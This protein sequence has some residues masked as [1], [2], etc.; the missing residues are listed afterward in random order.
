MKFLNWLAPNLWWRLSVASPVNPRNL[1]KTPESSAAQKHTHSE[2]KPR[3]FNLFSD[4]VLAYVRNQVALQSTPDH[5]EL[6]R[7]QSRDVVTTLHLCQY[8]HTHTQT[9]T[10]TQT[11]E[12]SH[13]FMLY[14][15]FDLFK[16][17]CFCTRRGV[18]WTCRALPFVICEQVY[19]SGKRCILLYCV[20]S[21]SQ[22]QHAPLNLSAASRVS[23]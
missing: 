22:Q 7:A 17:C 18:T 1:L 20:C 5:L 15:F 14:W 8:T 10:H 9:E 4:S 11:V 2:S 13:S 6:L 3:D 12:C 21:V 23:H 16:L 19:I